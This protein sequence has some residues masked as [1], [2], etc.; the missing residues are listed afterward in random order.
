MKKKIFYS[1][2]VILLALPALVKAQMVPVNP[3]IYK[4]WF[5]LGE[6]STQLDVSARIL[7][8]TSTNQVHLQI[9]NENPNNQ[10]AHFDIEIKNNAD[11]VKFITEISFAAQK[12]AIH[13]AN[14]TSDASLEA[15]KINLPATYDPTNI[16]IKI[17]FK[18]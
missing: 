17:I 11:G 7:K 18:P 13:T 4:E 8:C 5:L 15:L 10:T 3:T 16:T 1:F 6:S 12:A 2:I 9:F 14:C